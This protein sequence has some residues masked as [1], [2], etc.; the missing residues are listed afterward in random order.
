VA[1]GPSQSVLWL[2]PALESLDWEVNAGR[3]EF[4]GL[5]NPGGITAVMA[6]CHRDRY[7][8]MLGSWDESLDEGL[9][10]AQ[11]AEVS[12]IFTEP[13]VME[14]FM[15]KGYEW[16]CTRFTWRHVYRLDPGALAISPGIAIRT[17]SERD[18]PVLEGWYHDFFTI[19]QKS[20]VRLAPSYRDF[21]LTGNTY[22]YEIDGR[23]V[24]ATRVPIVGRTLA[25]LAGSFTPPELRG[26]GY[27]TGLLAAV[28][29]ELLG[30]G[31]SVLSDPEDCNGASIAIKEKLGFR[32]VGDELALYPDWSKW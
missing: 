14:A 22:V 6:L 28:C 15:A 1:A 16:R 29:H 2:I 11:R 7:G 32:K 4:L 27:N 20:P 19:E 5:Q 26:R 31:I 18:I 30:Q 24:S 17:V 3:W 12:R 8:I 13:R 9:S 25:K 23:L 21:I 10:L